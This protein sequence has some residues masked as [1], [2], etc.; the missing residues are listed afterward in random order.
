MTVLEIYV[1]ND[2]YKVIAKAMAEYKARY[3]KD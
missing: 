3:V 2:T 1:I